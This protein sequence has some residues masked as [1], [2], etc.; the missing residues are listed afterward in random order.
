MD[1]YTQE[2]SI[3][4]IQT[5]YENQC[6]LKLTFCDFFGVASR[7]NEST[8][9]RF[10][11]KF[12]ETGSVHD[13]PKSARTDENIA[14]VVQSV[15]DKPSTSILRHSQKLGIHPTSVWRILHKTKRQKKM[16]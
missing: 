4:I 3:Q 6:S 1:T 10:V 16:L 7:P 14:A 15:L 11:K 8:I 2:Q 9:Q 12:E 5:Y 13:K